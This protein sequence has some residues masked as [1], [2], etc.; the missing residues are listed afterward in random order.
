MQNNLHVAAQVDNCQ[1]RLAEH[2]PL[3][4]TAQDTVSGIHVVL[5]RVLTHLCDASHARISGH[6]TIL[7]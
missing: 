6:G 5:N 1:V 4:T 2:F 7:T 3:D